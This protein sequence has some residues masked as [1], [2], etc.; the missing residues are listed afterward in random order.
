MPLTGRSLSIIVSSVAGITQPAVTTNCPA[1][2][3]HDLALSVI[4]YGTRQR[5]I[6]LVRSEPRRHAR[7]RISLDG[8]DL[9][10]VIEENSAQR[11]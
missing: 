8:Q 2:P 1:N 9:P 4:G 7:P 10:A 5:A 11:H 6:S 3:Y